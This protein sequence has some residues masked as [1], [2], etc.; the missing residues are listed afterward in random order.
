M[1]C[2]PFLL[3][4]ILLSSCWKFN[5][6]YTSQPIIVPVEKVW[7]SKPVYAAKLLAEKIKYLSAKQ[8]VLRA[9]NIYAYSHY[10]FQVDVGSG[11]HVIDNSIPSKAERIG[12]IIINGCEQISIRGN[13]LY[14]NSYADL[15]T[16]DLSDIKNIREV[17]RLSN[18]FPENMYAYPFAMPDEIGPYTCPQYSDSVVVGWVRD[19][20]YAACYKN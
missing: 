8:T 11:I 16:I 3:L 15:V 19:S 1:K 13:Y 20:I 7:G 2:L 18:V 4:A 14:T 9:G 10:V 17:R 5:N 6:G 12:F